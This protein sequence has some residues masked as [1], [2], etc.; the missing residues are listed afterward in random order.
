MS[1]GAVDPAC[2]V[3]CCEKIAPNWSRS[4]YE[5]PIVAL[6]LLASAVLSAPLLRTIWLLTASKVMSL[7]GWFSRLMFSV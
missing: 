1:T 2:H 6:G 3:N 4:W 5:P 7:S